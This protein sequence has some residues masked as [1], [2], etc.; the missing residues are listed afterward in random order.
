MNR[1]L[2]IIAAV[3]TVGMF[4]PSAVVGQQWGDPNDEWCDDGNRRG[5]RGADRFCEVR[6]FTLAERDMVN[7]DGGSNGG[8]EI[9]GWD[10]NEIL[11]RAKVQAWSDREDPEDIVSDIEIITGGREIRADGP[12][13]RNRRRNGGWS[14]SFEVMVPYQSNLSLEAR[15]G[16][17]SI[18]DV[19]GN[20][21]FRTA[22]GGIA[23]EGVSGDV[24]GSTTNGGIRIE[25][26]GEEW[27][28]RG[29][30]VQSTNGGV[31]LYL[32]ADY[33][34]DLETG[35][36]NG[37]FRIDF[38]I[39]VQGRIN[40]RRIRTELNGGGALIRVVTTNGGVTV[41]RR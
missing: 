19:H 25:L 14:V 6:E 2:G 31:T 34:A 27:E 3:A 29:L 1:T 23:L 24:R 38:P 9:V 4:A 28:G 35:T 41:R 36:T 30:D 7:I 37:G 26:E 32:P 12:R 11:V 8:I 17:I 39:V 13:R 18:T 10:R 16:G 15:N 5:N 33:R 20:M 40:R 21:D 22:N